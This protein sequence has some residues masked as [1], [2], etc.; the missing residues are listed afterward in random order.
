MTAAL[1]GMTIPSTPLFA[2]LM[3]LFFTARSAM[4]ATS[5]V[6][7]VKYL[8]TSVVGRA[9]GLF[10]LMAAV[11]IAQIQAGLHCASRHM[12]WSRVT[13]ISRVHIACT[14]E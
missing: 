5:T 12:L 7:V 14:R 10:S 9:E 13:P 1:F 8:P 4:T 6:I 3:V 11:V 2:V